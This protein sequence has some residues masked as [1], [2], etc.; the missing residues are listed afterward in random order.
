MGYSS[1]PGSVRLRPGHPRPSEQPGWLERS[2]AMTEWRELK[3]LG[4]SE[5]VRWPRSKAVI[6]S[7]PW[8][9]MLTSGSFV[10]GPLSIPDP[11][12]SQGRCGSSS[13]LQ[14]KYLFRFS[15]KCALL[16]PSC[17]GTRGVSRS[18]RHARRGGDGREVLQR[19]SARG[20]T[21][22]RGREVVWSWRRDAGAKL[23][24]DDPGGDG[25]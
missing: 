10:D 18:S 14:Q 21:A 24:G 12:R 1:W 6:G 2:P 7:D 8:G 9:R 11:C 25:G 16:R 5:R 20:R 13:A 19:V 23:S 22:V 17:F 4:S 15:R 3:E